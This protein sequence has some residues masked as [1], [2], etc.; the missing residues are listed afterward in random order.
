MLAMATL[1]SACSPTP[2]A[3]ADLAL[4]HVTV[5]DPG[6]EALIEDATVLIDDG[7]I[8]AVGP[9]SEIRV[10]DGAEEMD[11]TGKFLMPGIID[12]HVHLG[13]VDGVAQSL[14]NYTR[15]NV[16]SQLRTYAAYGVTAVQ[17]LGT[18]KDIIH[19]MA[20]PLREG[21]SEFA[22]V[23][24]AGR[25]IVYAGSYGGV[26]GLEQS[27][28]T[29]EEA[30]AMVAR[31]VEKGDD[32]IKLWVDD[33]FGQFDERMPSAIS[34]AIIEEAHARGR[35]AVGHI[36]Y[37]ENARELAGFGIN[38]FVHEVRDQAID[39]QTLQLMQQNNVAQVAATLS[40]EASFTTDML[41]FVDDPFFARAVRPSVIEEL[42]SDARR[43]RLRA[44][45][46]FSRYPG[47]LD[48]AL[49]NFGRQARAGIVYGMGTDSGPAGRFAGYFAHWELELMVRAGITPREA[50]TAATV[51]NAGLLGVEDLGR[52][53]PGYQADLLVLD[54]D[55]LTDIRN[56]R[57]IHAVFIGGRSVP[58]IWQTCVDRPADACGAEQP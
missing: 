9:S 5:F 55:P 40:R 56:T 20:P 2:S 30:R 27:V 38:G 31:E 57:A 45:P 33:E 26:A 29:P 19:E 1:L 12:S 21:P 49:A 7:R 17:V 43:A 25:G 54:R 44:N 50:L 4:T 28:G 11:L 39:D 22:R 37:L 52:V 46:N 41:P 36:F 15:E 53:A 32:V 51:T 35:R 47:V 14:D 3:P 23:W 8:T 13:L 16:E 18:D 34:Q 24:T 10:P 48:N 42:K 58:T 6:S